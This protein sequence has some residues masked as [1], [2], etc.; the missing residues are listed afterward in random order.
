MHD[1]HI[2]A[3]AGSTSGCVKLWDIRY[4]RPFGES[5]A[6]FTPPAAH[7]ANERRFGLSSLSLDPTRTK[8]VASAT[9]HRCVICRNQSISHAML[10][11]MNH[12]RSC[13]HTIGYTCG[14]SFDQAIS[15]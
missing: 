9:N 13:M 15:P 10:S 11:S 4:H 5:L 1:E 14:I 6:S 7:V 8:V 12:L 2:L 3:S